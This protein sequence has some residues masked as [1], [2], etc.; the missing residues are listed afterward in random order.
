MR[1]MTPRIVP[2]FLSNAD[3]PNQCVFCNRGITAGASP[4]GITP[5]YFGAVLERPG[6]GEAA[7]GAF[8]GGEFTG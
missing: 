7:Q 4:A 8:Y 1:A 3:C 2:F 5:E 6:G